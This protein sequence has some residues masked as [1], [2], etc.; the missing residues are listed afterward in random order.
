[1]DFHASP[2]DT[3][4]MIGMAFAVPLVGAVISRVFVRL[5]ISWRH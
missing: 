2:H 1:M 3:A 4:I 5:V